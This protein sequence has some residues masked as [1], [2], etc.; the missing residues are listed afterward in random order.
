MK[1]MMKMFAEIVAI[2]AVAA[3]GVWSFGSLILIACDEHPGI[4]TVEGWEHGMAMCEKHDLDTFVETE[5]AGEYIAITT[6]TFMMMVN[7]DEEQY[8]EPQA[9]VLW[10]KAKAECSKY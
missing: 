1:A 10:N 7:A 4:V 8:A 3:L 9:M 5:V 6:P 2:M